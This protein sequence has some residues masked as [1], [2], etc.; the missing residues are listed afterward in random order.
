MIDA[1]Y[2]ASLVYPAIWHD[3]MY[4]CS[5]DKTRKQIDDTFFALL[6]YEQNSMWQSIKMYLA[7]RLFGGSYFNNPGSC[8][9]A[10]IQFEVNKAKHLKEDND[11]GKL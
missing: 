4:T 1:P 9:V 10:S 8:A 3:Y 5:T 7:V 2:K 6:R 11:H